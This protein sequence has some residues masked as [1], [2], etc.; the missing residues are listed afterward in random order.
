MT[1]DGDAHR[2]RSREFT[3]A[4]DGEQYVLERVERRILDRHSREHIRRWEQTCGTS[5]AQ[6]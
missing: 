5:E 3:E 4:S 6:V 2:I 1:D